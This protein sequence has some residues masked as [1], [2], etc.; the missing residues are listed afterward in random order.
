MHLFSSVCVPTCVRQRAGGVRGQLT[1]LG[2]LHPLCTV[3]GS[4]AKLSS[5]TARQAPLPGTGTSFKETSYCVF[6][7]VLELFL[8]QPVGCL[9]YRCITPFLLGGY[10]ECLGS[11]DP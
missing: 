5:L 9:A 1:G 8:L 3:Q 10:L 11:L 7:N 4:N 2:F 6:H